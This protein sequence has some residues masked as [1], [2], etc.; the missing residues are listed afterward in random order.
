MVDEVTLKAQLNTA[1]VVRALQ[2]YALQL[3]DNLDA[4]KKVI[5]DKND[6]L[7]TAY[8]AFNKAGNLPKDEVADKETWCKAYYELATRCNEELKKT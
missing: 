3:E 5:Q 8:Y 4:A 2:A 6:L 7:G 1:L